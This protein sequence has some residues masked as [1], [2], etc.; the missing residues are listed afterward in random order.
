MKKPLLKW[1]SWVSVAVAVL[2]IAIAALVTQV[3]PLYV[4]GRLIPNLA[5]TFD[6]EPERVQVRRVSLWGADLGPIALSRDRAPALAVSAVQLDYSPLSLLQGEVLGITLVG[7]EVVVQ[8][9]PRGLAIAGVD[10]P[11]STDASSGTGASFRL[12]TLLPVT[13]ERLSIV[14]SRVQILWNAHR[15]RLPVEVHLRTDRLKSGILEGR[16]NLAL[17]GNPV[18]LEA[19]IDQSANQARLALTANAVSLRRLR[20]LLPQDAAD[21]TGQADVNGWCRFGLAPLQMSG[22]SMTARVENARLALPNGRLQTKGAGAPGGAPL[23]ATL[24]GERLD[25]LTWSAAPFEIE[26]PL[27]LAVDTLQGKL[28]VDPQRWSLTGALE[29]L[30]PEQALAGGAKLESDL[31]LSWTL[32]AAGDRTAGDR[33]DL[34]LDSRRSGPL[35][36]VLGGNRLSGKQLR[37]DLDGHYQDGALAAGARIEAQGLGLTTP[38]GRVHAPGASASATVAMQPAGEGGPASLSAAAKLSDVKATSGSTTVQ[39]P[40]I[41]LELNGRARPRHPWGVTGALHLAHGR[42]EDKASALRA[43]GLSAVLPFAWPTAA[44]GEAGR[45]DLATIRWKAR[46]LGELKGIVRQTPTGVEMDLR[47]TSALIPGMD[48]IVKGGYGPAGARIELHVP[49]HETRADLDLGPLFPAAAG[50]LGGARISAFAELVMDGQGPKGSGRLKVSGGHLHQEAKGLRV[51]GINLAIQMHDLL[52]L[53]S[54]PQQ[55]L[56]VARLVLGDLEA[57]QLSVDFQLEN[58]HTLLIEKAGLAWC[59]GQ[60][61]TSALRI[62]SGKADYDL[63]L[64]C[65]RLNLADL[66]EQLG[67][68]EASGK[69]SVNGRIPIRYQAGRLRFDNGF[70][71]STPGQQGTIRLSGTEA[72]LAGLPPGSPQ[73]TQLD[74]ATEALKD[75]SYRWAK[76]QL[77]SEKEILLLKLELDGK[78]NRLL[79]FAYNQALGRFVRVAGAG[80]A[81]FKGISIDLNFRSP[82]N[83][84][85]HYKELLTPK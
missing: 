9:G 28:A 13:L 38:Q 74:I 59:R 32:T 81:E 75:Y 42:F 30:V 73:H 14:N 84:I 70:L 41:A 53:K 40:E 18:F 68:A 69:G 82:L 83:E 44:A 34:A 8:M 20:A 66:L 48:V 5:D 12:A 16:A 7:L 60:V 25:D 43:D 3:L 21:L 33:I 17:L 54:A 22:L 58:D 50:I 35:R 72:L 57:Q 71:Y 15:Y 26:G 76:L 63:I 37:V 45:L 10:L 85:I 80:Q 24:S 49:P 77:K 31:P 2:L 61:N 51:E 56:Q 27:E 78:P 64:Y 67:A 23:V 6:L 65:D 4:E 1:L 36:V 39:L 52:A 19:R 79:P 11:T 29:A 46:S 55:H 47:H 62:D